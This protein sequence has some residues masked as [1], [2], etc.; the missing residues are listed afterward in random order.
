MDVL[1]QFFKLHD[2]GTLSDAGLLQAV[3]DLK[4]HQLDAEG[5]LYAGVTALALIAEL[6]LSGEVLS[7][8]E[9]RHDVKEALHDIQSGLQHL[10]PEDLA[11]LQNLLIHDAPYVQLLSAAV[12]D[13]AETAHVHAP[14]HGHHGDFVLF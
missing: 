4:P 7:P 2:A 13:L 9:L 6:A 14:S 5:D 10:P 3:V 12:E 1:D 8:K 11:G